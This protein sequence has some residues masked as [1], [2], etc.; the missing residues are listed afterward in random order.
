MS[1]TDDLIARIT[2]LKDAFREANGGISPMQ[3]WLNADDT[4]VLKAYQAQVDRM[5]V[6]ILAMK[7]HENADETKVG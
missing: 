1:N 3:L 5:P 4:A 6:K 7:V 2:Q